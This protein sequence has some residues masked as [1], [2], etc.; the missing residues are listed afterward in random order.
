MAA[1]SGR[2]GWPE[3]WT[4]AWRSV[5]ILT[6][7]DGELVLDPADGDL[8]AGDLLGREDDEI[9]L[10]HAQF[11][12]AE[13]DPGERGAALALAAGGDDHDVARRQLHRRVEV[14]R[15]GEIG[16]IADALGDPEDP[17]ERAAGDADPAAGVVGDMAEGLQAG[18]VGREGGDEHPPLRLADDPVEALAHRR[19]GAGRQLLE[20]VGRIADQSEHALVADRAQLRLGA[21]I[22]ELGGVV[23]LP[24]AGVED[25]AVGRVDQQRIALGDRMG[26][27]DVAEAER[28]EPELAADLDDVDLDLLG[29]PLLLELAGDQAGGEGRR[30]ERNAEIGGE[31]GDGADMVL[32][33]VGQDDAEQIVAILLDEGQV[34]EDQLDPGIGRVGEGHAEIDHDPLAVAAVEIDVHADLA[35]A[36]EREE[37]QFFAGFH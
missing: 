31:I 20:D 4:S 6:P 37:E 29:Q 8:V 15:L 36:A 35:R 3:T 34:G 11:V 18:G 21:R 19:F 16:Q 12:L 1:S 7:R 5:I 27:R 26:E 23:Q 13:G 17:V 32:M 2:P 25:A 14:D 22:A 33:A 30:V 24:V 9:A 10:R 28:A